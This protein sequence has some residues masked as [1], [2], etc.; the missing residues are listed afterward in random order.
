[1][2]P[3]RMT[4]TS[5]IPRS[6]RETNSQAMR[7]MAI[8]RICSL[9]RAALVFPAVILWL[10]ADELRPI[11]RLPD[12]GLI[13]QRYFASENIGWAGSG[14]GLWLTE[15]GGRTWDSISPTGPQ[16]PSGLLFDFHLDNKTDGW[17]VNFDS[18]Y[19]TEDRERSWT[20]VPLPKPLSYH[21]GRIRTALT[22]Q[23]CKSVF[24]G[25]GMFRPAPAGQTHFD[26]SAVDRSAMPIRV[27]APIILKTEDGGKTWHARRLAGGQYRVSKL[28]FSDAR[29]GC[30][31]SDVSR[32]WT[33]DAGATWNKAADT[34]SVEPSA[35]D[36][37]EGKPAA[38]VFLDAANGWVSYSDG[39]L[40]RTTDG[41]RAW[42]SYGRP[43]QQ[44]AS[45]G[46][47]WFSA[48]YFVSPERGFGLSL[49][50][51]QLWKTSDGGRTWQHVILAAPR[52]EAIF[53]HNEH[54]AVLVAG[55]Q[56]Y[57]WMIPAAGEAVLK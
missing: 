27:L 54:R 9:G 6:E 5:L 50:D 33:A 56:L 53:F 34:F 4:C 51:Q 3:M 45:S 55:G 31:F 1:M 24:V 26:N 10:G 23:G 16:L 8:S 7:T 25:G 21:N 2:C 39:H 32:F 18:L 12:I 47:G 35:Q 11:A 44:V 48:L 57:E 22:R 42:E 28:A 37:L 43:L 41:G 30:L 49:L 40:F 14:F 52:I 38:V 19:C 46:A 17:A 13:S 20:K 29:H 36:V 15:D